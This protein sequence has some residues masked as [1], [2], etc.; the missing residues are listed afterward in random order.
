MAVLGQEIEFRPEKQPENPSRQ[1]SV[2]NSFQIDVSK[3]TEEEWEQMLYE[4][5]PLR[6]KITDFLK[7]Q[8][9]NI[10]GMFRKGSYE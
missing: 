2:R 8:K 9:E 4:M 6:Y 3:L 1:L 7:N 5:R 10:F